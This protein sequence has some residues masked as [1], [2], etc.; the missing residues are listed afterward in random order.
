MITIKQNNLLWKNCFKKNIK[1]E[2]VSLLTEEKSPFK[3]K[4]DYCH[5]VIS[6]PRK[7]CQ[8]KK[9]LIEKTASSS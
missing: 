7:S 8:S 6:A 4:N 9:V 3:H 2:G 1:I 5:L